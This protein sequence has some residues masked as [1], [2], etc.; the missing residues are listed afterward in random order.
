MTK[1]IK[2]LKQT[3]EQIMNSEGEV[4]QL[5]PPLESIPL[6]PA[7]IF[8]D[9]FVYLQKEINI[10]EEK[11]ETLKLKANTASNG[12]EATVADTSVRGF[13]GECG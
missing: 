4:I 9:M 7:Q 13:D 2:N 3:F 10:L 11:V 8:V 6:S 1:E 5:D 12:I